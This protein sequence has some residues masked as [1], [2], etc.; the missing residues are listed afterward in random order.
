MDSSSS[1]P[2]LHS[3]RESA[4][5]LGRGVRDRLSHAAP[6]ADPGEWPA[7]TVLVD[8]EAVDAG[9]ALPAPL[10]ELRDRIQV[11]VAQAQAQALGRDQGGCDVV[12][13]TAR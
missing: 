13:G 9:G 5:R 12:R 3:V 2:F 1:T 7:A 11:D 4:D 10:A 8:R 6:G